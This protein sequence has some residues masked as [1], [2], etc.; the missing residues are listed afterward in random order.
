MYARDPSMLTL[1]HSLSLI[2]I[3]CGPTF[4]Q[5]TLAYFPGQRLRRI[6]ALLLTHAHADAILGLDSLRAW[7]MG[8][9]ARSAIQD[10]VDIYCT[11]ECF[12]GVRTL[13]PYLVDT[14]QASGSGSVG[15]LRFHVI[16]PSK[17]FQI[18]TPAGV[19]LRT[20]TGDVL[21]II[22]LPVWHGYS[23][24][25]RALFPCLGFR[26]DTLS[27]VSDTHH[28]P[29]ETSLKMS[30]SQLLVLDSL[31]PAKHAS[32]FSLTQAVSM[33]L[34][35]PGDEAP[36]LALLTDLTHRLEHHICDATL[37]TFVK[38][39]RA[40]NAETRAS[41]HKAVPTDADE[42]AVG[43]GEGGVTRW[44]H[45]AWDEARSERDGVPRMEKEA[46]QLIK[47]TANAA[48]NGAAAAAQEQPATP[49]EE[50][51]DVPD[52]RISW[53]GQVVYFE[54]S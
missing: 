17:P 51:N 49:L 2:L 35:L 14:S 15:A 48:L 7:T 52:I 3:D 28:I 53:D 23:G 43:V 13:F 46:L 19:P 20:T 9:L 5:S 1:L 37:R 11:Q 40:W 10:Y 27:Y 22:P 4:Y 32:H 24:P 34:S 25:S 31:S 33:A 41:A 44:W 8:G 39:L 38:Q 42:S 45:G 18:K 16:D 21:E 36:R 50:Q 12:D 30:G 29:L 26:L 6:A 54:R 47:G